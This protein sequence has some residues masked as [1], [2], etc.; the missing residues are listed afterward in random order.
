MEASAARA[1]KLKQ[2]RVDIQ[3]D[4]KRLKIIQLKFM[5]GVLNNLNFQ[6]REKQIDADRL[7]V[8]IMYLNKDE[9]AEKDKI[10]RLMAEGLTSVDALNRARE[11]GQDL[12]FA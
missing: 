3:D 4:V 10:K 5:A 7:A 2:Q 1:R 9:R 11:E 8:K 12:V 6:E